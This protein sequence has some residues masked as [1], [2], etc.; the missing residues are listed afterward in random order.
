MLNMKQ[1]AHQMSPQMLA[2]AHQL[3]GHAA[4]AQ[5]VAKRLT[6]HLSHGSESAAEEKAESPAVQKAEG[7]AGEHQEK[8]SPFAKKSNPFAK[9]S[10]P[11]S[12]GKY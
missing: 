4:A 7:A 8:V 2:L 10:N 1:K 6:G 11:F 12:K 9:K 3:A 5:S